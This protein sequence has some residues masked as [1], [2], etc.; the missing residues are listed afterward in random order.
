MMELS[1]ARARILDTMT[2]TGEELV[3]LPEAS[4]RVT[5]A[6]VCARLSNPP[7]DVSS[8]DG[9]AVRAAEAHAGAEL[10]LSAESP[11]GHPVSC[12][13]ESGGCI[14][15]FTGSLMP[16]GADAVVIQENTERAGDRIRI[17]KDVKPGQFIRRAGQDFSAGDVLV[18]AG[19]RLEARS[20]GLAA[21]GN[22]PWVRVARR[23]RVAI[24]ATGDEISMP[25]EALKLGGIIGSAGV[26]LAALLKDAGADPVLL[27]V[28]RDDRE[29]IRGLVA[30]LE[31][32]DLLVT[33]GGASVGDYDLVKTALKEAGMVMDF[34]KVAMRPGKPLM[35]GRLG[36]M[37]VVG[38]PG[39]PVAAFVCGLQFLVPAVR[40]MTGC[41]Q[42]MP[43]PEMVRAGADLQPN[44]ERAD[45]LRARLVRGEDGLL[46][47]IPF[48]RQDSAMMATL[49]DCDAL[50]LR[51]PHAELLPEGM[52]CPI[53]RPDGR[54][55]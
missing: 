16:E 25:G 37:P 48:G 35:S 15:I 13:V 8:M 42:I 31:G 28:A 30:G 34:W 54:C 27:P 22:V 19:V 9:Y 51:P 21:A 46:S 47:A 52:P 44:D 12:P 40:K 20:V 2:G 50:I 39:N 6:P 29:D 53:L 5:A 26:M 3:S 18:P 45:H 41:T 43:E 14:R 7:G 49:S 10:R 38:V 17:L 1:A 33:I 24:L 4:G 23:P 11:A 36:R 32:M 55:V